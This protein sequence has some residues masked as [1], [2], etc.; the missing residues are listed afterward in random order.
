MHTVY[1]I[2]QVFLTLAIAGTVLPSFSFPWQLYIQ[3][4]KIVFLG[5]SRVRTPPSSSLLFSASW[6]N[7]TLNT[8]LFPPHLHSVFSD[9]TPP[10]FSSPRSF[11][12]LFVPTKR[13]FQQRIFIFPP[14]ADPRSKKFKFTLEARAQF[15]S[16]NQPPARPATIKPTIHTRHSRTKISL[17]CVFWKV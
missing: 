7:C 17:N 12:L 8:R 11:S 16:H 2:S 9:Q 15:S 13:L 3:K 5:R 4:D 6:F 14:V 1:H 10:F